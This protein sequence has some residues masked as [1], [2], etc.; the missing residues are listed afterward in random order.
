MDGKTQTGSQRGQ[1]PTDLLSGGRLRGRAVQEL[2]RHYGISSGT[3]YKWK[4]KYGGLEAS[5][6]KRM[7]ELEHENRR[8]RCPGPI[9]E[10]FFSIQ[11]FDGILPS[12]I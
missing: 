4:A 12:L 10:L 8:Y 3:Y 7:N 11:K 1:R 9:P 5:D 6:V 2:W